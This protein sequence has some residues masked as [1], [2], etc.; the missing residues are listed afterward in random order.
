[1]T[2]IEKAL[3]LAKQMGQMRQREPAPES[4]RN[5][6]AQV[7]PAAATRPRENYAPFP[8]IEF[9]A[10]VCT[11][12]H[13]LVH[14]AQFAGDAGAAASYRLLR[15]R[16]GHRVKDINSPCIG[17]M[18]AGPGEGKTL[19][20]LNL[21]IHVARDKQ[22][23]VYLLDLDMRNPSVFRTVGS[24][25]PRD[26]SEFLAGK[27]KAEDVLFAT[28]IEDLVFA[29][30]AGPTQGAS[31]LLASPR[32]DELL[33][34]IRHRSPRAF[35]IC[36]LPPVMSTDEP[37]LVAPRTDCIL[38]VVSENVTRRDRLARALDMLGDFTIAGIVVNR[39]ME[40]VGGDYYG[41]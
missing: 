18:S 11:L 7:D 37:L 8:V 9:D 36:D 23:T 32:L 15:G 39:S 29:G 2:S 14:D 34:Y 5:R 13:V 25:P 20:G 28:P 40:E 16:L 1:M 22:H 31:E 35:I 21:A 10:Q 30:V 6:A 41:Y 12:N 27:L 26:L 33:D 24:R 4:R 3:E 17:L 38:L 19:T